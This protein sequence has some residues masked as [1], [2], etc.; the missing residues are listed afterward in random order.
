[1]PDVRR[2]EF[3]AL[4]GGAAA[5]WPL[6]AGAQQ[7]AFPVIGLLSSR[8][9]DIDTPLISVIRQALNEKGLVE[10]QNVAL[11]Y[12][13]AEGQYDRLAKLAAEL[14][15]QQV[16][17][18]VTMGGEPAALAAKAATAT[19]PIVFVGGSDPIRVGL[20]TNLHRPGGNTTGV[21][22]LLNEME[23]KRLGLLG[24]L[25]PQATTI[26]VLVNTNNPSSELQLNDIQTAAR[27]VGREINILNASTIRDIDAAFATLAQMRA[28][29]LFVAA[30]PFFFTRAAQ[31]V[32]LA[33]RHA[34]PALYFRR[35]FATAGG[36][37]SYGANV[38]EAYRVLGAYAA[39]ILKGEKPG[40]LPIQLAT[41]FELVINLST[42]RALGFEMPQALLA[43]ADEVIE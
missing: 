13:W 28:D 18:I 30:D 20:V 34:V 33:A 43:R 24:E 21:S 15:R 23:P 6:A 25:R 27:N 3:I 37:V 39:R 14:V 38:N 22:M 32:V 9:P 26:A 5:A 2:R 10:G 17:V 4:L 19:I 11:D 41:K 29:A 1:M 40:D 42:A 7:R 16:G 36:L 35:E 31:L 12:R 8:S